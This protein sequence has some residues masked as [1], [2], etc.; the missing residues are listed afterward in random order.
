MD[1]TRRFPIGYIKN[2]IYD[3]PQ[4]TLDNMKE[5]IRTAFHSIP[6]HMLV[7]VNHVFM[8]IICLIIENAGHHFEHLLKN[9]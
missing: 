8:K 6:A 1:R 4:T 3:I 5:R 9:K 7:T 2:N